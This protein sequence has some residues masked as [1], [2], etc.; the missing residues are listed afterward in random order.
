V[1][2]NAAAVAL[3]GN[4]LSFFRHANERLLQGFI[5]DWTESRTQA[6]LMSDAGHK[7]VC[8][9]VLTGHSGNGIIIVEPGQ[10]VPQAPLY[11]KYQKKT[12][13]YRVHLGRLRGGGVGTID[14]QRKV[15]DPDREPTDWNVRSHQNGFIYIRNSR[16]GTPLT[17]PDRVFEAA[18]EVFN[19]SGL[20]FGAVDV[21]YHQSGTTEPGRAWV[22]EINTAPGLEGT[23]VTNYNNF[24]RENFL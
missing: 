15:R 2:N 10:Q 9:T 4:K 19:A 24:I 7:V 21:I 13:E 18:R 3:C 12:A 17:M 1:L 16:D 22:L 11:T 5:P 20:S 23:T 14:F 6:Q 8:R